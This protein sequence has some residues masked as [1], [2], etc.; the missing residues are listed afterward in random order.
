MPL[1][2]IPGPTGRLEA[3][4]DEPLEGRSVDADGL[5]HRGRP[6]GIRAAV[7]FGH[8]HPEQGGTMH[9]KVV[10]QAA[11]ALARTGSAVLRIN[12]R[13]AGA[14]EGS[15]TGS[16]GAMED[17]RSALDFMSQRFPG[18][19]LWT[20]GMS[21]GSWVSMMVGADDARVSTLIGIACPISKYDWERVRLSPKPKFFIH[22]ERD[23]VAPLKDIRE[24]YARAAEPKELV[25]IDGADHLF[26]GK[27][28]DVADAVED[29]LGDWSC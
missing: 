1:R 17:F 27:V 24:F 11:K 2:E 18:A 22:G 10:Y 28:G 4:L 20:A 25:V 9:T 29:L 6:E 15:F 16:P 13:G 19:R 3:L 5:V 26:D 8:P 14:S 7:V 12:F 23:E 21:F